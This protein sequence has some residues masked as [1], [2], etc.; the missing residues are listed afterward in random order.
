MGID[1]EGGLAEGLAHDDRGGLVS[2]TG[3]LLEQLH[4]LR[5]GTVIFF[6]ENFRELGNRDRFAGGETAGLDDFADRFDGDQGHRLRGVGEFEKSGGDLIDSLVGA[7]RREQDRNEQC[8][9]IG[10]IQGDW[11]LRIECLESLKDV[12]RPLRFRHDAGS[13]AAATRLAQI[14]GFTLFLDLT[15]HRPDM[16]GMSHVGAGPENTGALFKAA[17]FENADR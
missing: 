2:N 3:E 12:R 10:V 4:V 6:D 14:T 9:R 11:R 16:V 7:L 17:P 5:H 8:V 13:G 1:G 15:Q